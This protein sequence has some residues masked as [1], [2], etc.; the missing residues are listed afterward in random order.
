MTAPR[1]KKTVVP[2]SM[3]MAMVLAVTLLL[4]VVFTL[5]M[6]ECSQRMS[7]ESDCYQ[8]CVYAGGDVERCREACYAY[9][10]PK[11]TPAGFHRVGGG[12]M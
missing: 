7:S 1:R 9:P 6:R 3:N 11:A 4:G 8:S 12:A 5:G 10:E 2:D